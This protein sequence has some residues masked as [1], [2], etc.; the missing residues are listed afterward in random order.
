MRRLTSGQHGKRHNAAVIATDWSSGNGAGT[1]GLVLFVA[2]MVLFAR[3]ETVQFATLIGARGAFTLGAWRVE[4][5]CR[6][7]RTGSLI[8]RRR[9]PS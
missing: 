5:G 2:A 9:L 3:G 1:P 8:S 6:R 4:V 7:R